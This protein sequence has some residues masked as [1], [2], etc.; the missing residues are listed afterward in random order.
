MNKKIEE[1]AE[2]EVF[3]L[4]HVSGEYFKYGMLVGKYDSIE[5]PPYYTAMRV[6]IQD[7]QTIKRGT[8]VFLAG[9]TVNIKE[10]R[11]QIQAIQDEQIATFK[12][13][14]DIQ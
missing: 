4:K 7:S 9:S 1:V 2:N 8:E 13:V 6:D 10:K 3:T 11:A 5:E 14:H 12:R